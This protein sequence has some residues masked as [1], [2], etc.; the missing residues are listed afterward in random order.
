MIA[1][2]EVMLDLPVRINSRRKYTAAMRLQPTLARQHIQAALG[3]PES[4]C[5]SYRCLLDRSHCRERRAGRGGGLG[6][7]TEPQ[8]PGGAWGPPIG[9][10]EIPHTFFATPIFADPL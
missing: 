2:L 8:G 4:Y 7:G 5:G 3:L 9:P 6:G 1:T 10:R